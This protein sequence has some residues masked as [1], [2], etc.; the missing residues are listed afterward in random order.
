MFVEIPQ[1]EYKKLLKGKLNYDILLR[2]VMGASALSICN[3]SLVFKDE[4]LDRIL[5]LLEPESYYDRIQ[6]LRKNQKLK[7]E[8]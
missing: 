6:E 8:E 1:D 3:D 2:G 5:N 7:K 4:E